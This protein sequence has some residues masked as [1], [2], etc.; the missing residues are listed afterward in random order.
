MLCI[1]RHSLFHIYF[2]FKALIKTAA[3][4]T[5]AIYF[6]KR[7]KEQNLAGARLFSRQLLLQE[8]ESAVF[9]TA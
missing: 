9:K 3:L 4:E 2:P 8:Q 7:N 6:L 5:I 1:K